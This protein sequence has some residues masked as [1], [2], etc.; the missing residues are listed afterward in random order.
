MENRAII[1]Q[2]MGAKNSLVRRK[3]QS[4]RQKI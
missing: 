2:T 3:F 1:T 4:A